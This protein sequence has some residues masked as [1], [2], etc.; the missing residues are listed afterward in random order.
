MELGWPNCPAG[1]TYSVGPI[2]TAPTCS[3]PGHSLAP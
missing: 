1:G 2:G 3:I